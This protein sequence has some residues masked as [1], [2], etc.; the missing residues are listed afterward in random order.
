M[1]YIR[2]VQKRQDAVHDVNKNRKSFV[3]HIQLKNRDVYQFEH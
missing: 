3:T 1:L 2:H